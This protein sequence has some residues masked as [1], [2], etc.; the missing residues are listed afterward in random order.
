MDPPS[1][2]RRGVPAR[3]AAVLHSHR[4]LIPGAEVWLP[5]HAAVCSILIFWVHLLPV[6]LGIV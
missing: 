3:R 6:M 5:A 2:R 4:R 1:I